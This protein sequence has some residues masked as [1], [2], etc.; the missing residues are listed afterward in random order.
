[1]SVFT[2]KRAVLSVV[3]LLLLTSAAYAGNPSP[4][5]LVRSAYDAGAGQ[6]VMFGGQSAF[7]TGTQLTYDSSETWIY[8]GGRWIQRHTAHAP[9]HRSF[10][11]MVYDAARSRVVLFGGRFQKPAEFTNY[12][13]LSDTW[14]W[15]NNDWAQ[16]VTAN[17]PSPRQGTDMAYDPVRDRIVLYGGSSSDFTT[18][19]VTNV[20][21]TWEFDGTDWTKVGTDEQ[22]KVNRPILEFDAARGETIMMGQNAELVPIMFRYKPDSHTWEE[23]KP[24]KMPTCVNDAAMVY[25]NHKRTLLLLGGVCGFGTSGADQTWEWNGTNWIEIDTPFDPSR[26]TGHAMSYDMRQFQTVVFGGTTIGA[27]APRSTTQVYDG[28]GWSFPFGNVRPSPRSLAAFKTD[29]VHK[30][31]WLISGLNEFSN[32]YLSDNWGYRNGQWF[33]APGTDA[34]SDCGGTLAAW[35]SDRS[36]LVVVCSGFQAS[37]VATFEFDGAAWKSISTQDEPAARRFGGLAYDP[38]LKKTVLFG[39]YD[40]GGNFRR[41]TWTFD[42]TNWTEVK[43]ERPENRSLFAMWYDPLQKRVLIY[44][45]LGRPDIDARVTRFSDMWAF[46][47]DRWTKLSVTETPGERFGPQ[48]VVDPRDNKLLLFGG[49]RA[50]KIDPEDD[51]VRRQFYD[52]DTWQWDGTASR[53]TKL[54]P[55][56][57][58]GVREN[59]MMAWDPLAEKIVL[60][61]GYAGL[62][63]SDIWIW[64]GDTWAPQQ[65]Q[66]GGR[67]RPSGGGEP[68]PTPN[69]GG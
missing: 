51:D 60:F 67:R 47:G 62:Y 32:G 6:I 29:P 50:E 63:F 40:T 56:N 30:T 10:H 24:E 1:M 27:A 68:P 36:K 48:I 61:G 69:P 45:G 12:E 54:S 35:D 52:N 9:T 26:V 58:P 28:V 31:V 15:K 5:T 55:A 7:D 44:G 53:W 64:T 49:M 65:E 4:R 3:A 66:G 57:S 22:V 42:G 18:A 38:T 19:L 11:A 43:N 33:L 39:G 17:A 46:A 23:I 59:G 34:P 2:P 13:F 8:N 16:I 37:E 41:D 14:V 25:Q 21:D 20:Y